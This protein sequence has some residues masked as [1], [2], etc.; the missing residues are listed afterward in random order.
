MTASNRSSNV[1]LVEDSE[2]DVLMT[3]RSFQKASFDIDLQHV[4]NGRECMDFLR[5]EGAYADAFAPD[6]ILL[7]INMPVMDG[8]QVLAEIAQD[9]E[10]CMLPVIVL[11]SSE[12]DEEVEQMYRLGCSS[13]ISKPADSSRFA[14]VIQ[15]LC[16]YWF[17]AVQ[18]P[19]NRSQPA[20]T[21]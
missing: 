15:H 16:S 21:R 19:R 11:T 17:S 6:L 9:K 5:R 18:L 8:R 4:P 1:L 3:T 14:E 2:I 12:S 7:D 10:L 13:F 20:R